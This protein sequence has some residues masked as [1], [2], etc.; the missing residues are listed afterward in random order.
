MP[1]NEASP[2]RKISFS[3][4]H[5]PLCGLLAIQRQAHSKRFA[6]YIVDQP[7]LSYPL[8]IIV[9]IYI[10]CAPSEDHLIA[11]Y[12]PPTTGKG[13][14]L[15]ASFGTSVVFTRES[16]RVYL[17][18]HSYT[19][20]FHALEVAL[21]YEAGACSH[22]RTSD[23][24]AARDEMPPVRAGGSGHVR[25]SEEAP[26]QKGRHLPRVFAGQ[27]E[28]PII[29]HRVPVLPV[30]ACQIEGLRRGLLVQRTVVRFSLVDRLRHV[31]FREVEKRLAGVVQLG[32]AGGVLRS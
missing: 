7:H 9:V 8:R 26:T 31:R 23:G 18:M 21:N 2:R 3:R 13:E 25:P 17:I 10:S 30:E 5:N 11:L 20:C 24:S 32:D 6:D 22:R 12:F 14:S 15:P 4:E 29:E 28:V 19:Q 16:L 27:T 1:G